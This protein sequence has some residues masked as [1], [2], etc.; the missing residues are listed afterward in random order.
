MPV[1]AVADV[2]TCYPCS[3]HDSANDH[4]ESSGIVLSWTAASLYWSCK[5]HLR[6][7]CHPT[8]TTACEHV[9]ITATD[10]PHTLYGIISKWLSLSALAQS[11]QCQKR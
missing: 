8:V 6:P 11:S 1:A 5:L 10:T 7:P 9:V 3:P 2:T 4:Y